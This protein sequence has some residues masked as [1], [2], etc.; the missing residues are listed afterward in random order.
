MDLLTELT[1]YVQSLLN[2]IGLEGNFV[3]KIALKFV[4]NSFRRGIWIQF[5]LVEDTFSLLG[6]PLGLDD[7]C[8]D[9][10]CIFAKTIEIYY[11]KNK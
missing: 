7:D 3:K 9:K 2:S 4:L 11:C 1:D 10:F 8:E 5:S 6:L